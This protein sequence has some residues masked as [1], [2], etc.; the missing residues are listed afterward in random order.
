MSPLTHAYVFRDDIESP[1]SCWPLPS[2]TGTF[3]N[4][5]GLF[6]VRREDRALR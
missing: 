6:S 5:I 4:R 2:T 3:C 1:S